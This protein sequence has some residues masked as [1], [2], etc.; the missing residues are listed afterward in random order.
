MIRNFHSSHPKEARLLTSDKIKN[1][2]YI[3]SFLNY[4]ISGILAVIFLYIAF[5]DVNFGEVLRLVSGASIFWVAAFILSF[6]LGHVIRT[7]RWKVILNSVKPHISFKHLFGALMVGYG[8][9]CVTPKLGEF[10]RAV[11]IG[12]WENLS[13]SSMLGTIIVE[14]VIDIVSLGSAVIISA[15]I[16]RENLYDKFPWLESTLY[17]AG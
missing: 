6:F 8:V 11:L 1:S 5:Y 9:N 15:Y 10:S 12:R 17:V 13:R 4:G 3:K 16:W 14:R 7:L 2:P